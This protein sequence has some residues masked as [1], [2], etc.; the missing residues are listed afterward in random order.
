MNLK[1]Y[2]EKQVRY[3]IEGDG[4]VIVSPSFGYEVA[5]YVHEYMDLEKHADADGMTPAY[6]FNILMGRILFAS[7]TDDAI[8]RAMD[9]LIEFAAAELIKNNRGYWEAMMAEAEQEAKYGY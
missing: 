6:Q 3:G 9:Y 8:C 4:K 2:V 1:E 7:D 5:D